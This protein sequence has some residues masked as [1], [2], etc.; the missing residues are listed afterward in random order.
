MNSACS[1]AR[2][3]EEGLRVRLANSLRKKVCYTKN[4]FESSGNGTDFY[5]KPHHKKKRE[6]K[7]TKIRLTNDK[8]GI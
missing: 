7:Q 6:W 4:Q 1:S 8:T 2:W 5:D 3:T